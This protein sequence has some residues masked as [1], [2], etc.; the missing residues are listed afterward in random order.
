M[1]R[2]LAI[3][4]CA[5]GLLAY[6]Q[7]YLN[8]DLPPEKRAADLVARLTLEEKVLQM[9]NSA[10]AIPRLGIP[11]YDWWNEGLH[12]VARAGLATVFPQAIALAA[13]WDTDLMGRVADAISTEARAKYNQALLNQD[14]SRYHGLTFWS[15]NINIFRDPRWGRGQ[16]TYGEDP[17]L[18]SRMA[19]AF[20][21]GMQGGD[22][23]YFKVIATAKH[24]AVHS[25]PEPLRHQFDVHPSERDLR[26]TYLP[27]FRASVVEGKAYSV[28][29]AYNSVNGE[30]A[31]ANPGLLQKILRG[32]WGFQGYIVSD[33]GAIAD[34]FGGHKFKASS[35]EASAAAVKAGVDLACT[36]TNDYRSLS[37]AVKAGLIAEAE[38]DRSLERLFVARFKLG[39][40]D[41][42]ERVPFSNIPYSEVDSAAHRELALE[43]ARKSIV[44]LKNQNRALPLAASLGGIA[45]IGPAAD[46]PDAL[47]GNYNGFSSKHVTPLEGMQTQFPGKIRFAPGAAYTAQTPSLIPAGAF[48]GGLTAEYFK[49]PNLQGPPE[50]RRI[51]PRPLL[52]PGVDPAIPARGFSVRWTG[53]LIAPWSGPYTFSGRAGARIALDGKEPPAPVTLEAG[54]A[55]DFRMEYRAP[56]PA[57]APR[58]LW[59]PPAEPMLAQ[60]VGI[61]QGAGV[62]VAFLGLN[63]NLEGEEMNVNIPGFSGGDRTDLNLPASQ[64]RLLEAAVQTGKPV[65]VVLS[66]GGALAVN[67]AAGR[68]AAV[69]EMWYAGEEAGTAI[70]ETLAGLNNPAGRLPVTFYKSADQLPPFDDYSMAGRTYRYFH[71]DPLYGFG[72]GL[73]YSKFRYSSL[74]ARRT[75]AGGRVT[76]RVKNDSLREG[77]EVA[78]LYVNGELRGFK[79]IHLRP[80][81][82]RAVEFSLEPGGLPERKARIAVGGGQPLPSIPHL[83][84]TL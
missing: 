12:G 21:Q 56:G 27:A 35:A 37:E 32:E 61:V 41:P 62:T 72:F 28:M 74:N 69:L 19:V 57:G 23:H 9:Q 48:A 47:L 67:Y 43:A 5:A 80:G 1:T 68:A 73:S 65:I 18:T 14:Y 49:N 13:T 66:S 50:L 30:P 71:G 54:R 45:V 4:L 51:E 10:P 77:D 81:E 58:A 15:P 83:E 55:Y 33:C 84:G 78:Q 63:P 82:T 46:D 6:S 2:T 31:C 39:M 17:F 11:A 34:I 52:Q 36:F 26:D 70:A 79:R 42:P 76:A 25:G 8:P 7:P 38:I 75:S 64:Q 20:I 53:R 22:P 60:A 44:L 16:E 29:C 59:I 24:F 3:A 40:F